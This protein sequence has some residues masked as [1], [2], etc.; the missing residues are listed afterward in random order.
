[1]HVK[2][3]VLDRV[4][5]ICWNDSSGTGFVIDVNNRQYLIT[6]RHVVEGIRSGDMLFVLHENEWKF[7]KIN[8]IGFG[9]GGL[10]I[11]VL[12]CHQKLSELNSVPTSVGFIYGQ[13]V[14]FLGY[15]FGWNSG[16]EKINR[17][18][19]F[20][21]IKSGIISGVHASDGVTLIYID[22]HVNS[23]FSG[24]P[25]LLVGDEIS[26]TGVVCGYQSPQAPVLDDNDNRV[27]Y[28]GENPGLFFC[29]GIKHVLDIIEKNP[30][31]FEI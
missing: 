29:V 21:F 15:P 20:P 28:F 22:G 12:S 17:G 14:L 10:D 5:N 16:G 8:I 27:G 11:A 1:M 25:L 24:G 3:D 19:P 7:V 9:E 6:A 30:D 13:A 2:S 18:I 26:I 4:F 31:G 23:G